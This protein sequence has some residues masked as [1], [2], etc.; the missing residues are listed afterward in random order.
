MKNL[1]Y[2][3]HIVRFLDKKGNKSILKMKDE[4]D[5]NGILEKITFYFQGVGSNSNLSSKNVYDFKNL[6]VKIDKNTKKIE[7]RE[8]LKEY[9][10]NY[11]NTGNKLQLICPKS[12][13]TNPNCKSYITIGNK[14]KTSEN[15]KRPYFSSNC[16]GLHYNESELHLNTK[17]E[18][19]NY[20]MEKRMFYLN[21]NSSTKIENIEIEKIFTYGNGQERR[22]DIYYEKHYNTLDGD[23][24][25]EKFAI[26]I[27][28]SNIQYNEL[29]ERTN[30]YKKND[31]AVFWIIVDEIFSSNK[32]TV[33]HLSKNNLDLPLL[34]LISFSMKQYNNRFFVYDIL[35]KKIIA[36]TIK[37]ENIQ[38]FNDLKD[39]HKRNMKKEYNTDN[40]YII[41]KEKKDDYY[42]LLPYVNNI[43]NNN[44]YTDLLSASIFKE[45]KTIM[46]RYY[47]TEKEKYEFVKFK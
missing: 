38:K 27:Q 12:N 44:I 6:T 36:L 4:Y 18:I 9:L 28:K 26:E 39:D 41:S 25:I 24:V 31:I 2:H 14:F 21:K 19:F 23:L 46:H 8:K 32:N 35:K 42:K 7:S 17:I 10:L 47:N 30:W 29:I 13:C 33:N 3:S 22:S 37:Q 20:L 15:T 40:L 45:T 34:S 1:K 16:N 5:K 11:C 43:N